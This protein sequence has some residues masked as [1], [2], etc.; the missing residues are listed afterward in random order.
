[1][2]ATRRST[3]PS[4][5]LPGV[6]TGGCVGDFLPNPSTGGA[7]VLDAL[8]VK[9]KPVVPAPNEVDLKDAPLVPGLLAAVARLDLVSDLESMRVGTLVVGEH[10]IGTLD[11]FQRL[12]RNTIGFSM[13]G[14]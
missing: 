10:R 12:S 11:V 3:A 9:G 1:M 6:G 5:Y 8:D 7:A 14:E 4:S 13:E 2:G